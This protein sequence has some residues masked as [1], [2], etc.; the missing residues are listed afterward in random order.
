MIELT[1]LARPYAKAVF[2][3]ALDAAIIDKT[4]A[5]AF[6]IHLFYFFNAKV[7]SFWTV[8]NFGIT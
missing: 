4:I 1:P 6:P 2:A 5:R 7:A 8:K 3:S